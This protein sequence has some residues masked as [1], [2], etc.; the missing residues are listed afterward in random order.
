MDHLTG[1]PI[2]GAAVSLGGRT[3]TVADGWYR[4]DAGCAGCGIC[5]TTFITV[6]ASGYQ[7][8]SRVV[9]RGVNGVERLDIELDPNP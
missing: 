1:R 4:I 9:G 6:S 3:T 2:A 8:F 5:N 7:T